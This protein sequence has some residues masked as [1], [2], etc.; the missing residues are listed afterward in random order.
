MKI[1]LIASF[2]FL[3][4]FFKSASCKKEKPQN[5]NTPNKPLVIEKNGLILTVLNNDAKFPTSEINR[6]TDVFFTVYPKLRA[7]FNPAASPN[8]TFRIDTAYKGVAATMGSE[9]VYNPDWFYR[10]P[11]DLD[12]VTHEAMHIVQ[13]YGNNQVPWWLTEGIADY[14]RFKYGVN[15]AAGG[16]SLPAYKTDQ[17][18]DNSY[19]V[20][21]RFLAW[22]ENKIK[23]GF[24]KEM[25]NV[26]RS[27]KFSESSWQT[28]SGKSVGELWSAYAANPEL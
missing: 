19:R 22:I 16:W 8:I 23:P 1:T 14:V 9:I 3:A 2:V 26:M 10:F 5:T 13:A 18:Y 15:N 21:A 7:D 25:D 28:I 4:T 27:G 11:E 24:V 20:T 6:L 12:V 17:N